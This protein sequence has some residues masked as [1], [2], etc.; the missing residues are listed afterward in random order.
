MALMIAESALH[1]NKSGGD[2]KTSYFSAKKM[3]LTP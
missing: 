1:R 2:Y 3:V